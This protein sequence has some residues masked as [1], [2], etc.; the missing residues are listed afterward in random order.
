MRTFLRFGVLA[1]AGMIMAVPATS[2]G[3]QKWIDAN[4]QVH[5][6]DAPPP[7]A[8]TQAVRVD[9]PPPTRNPQPV[10]IPPPPAGAPAQY[11][12]VEAERRARLAE[13]EKRNQQ[14]LAAQAAV[15]A[16]TQ[17]LNDHALIA[18][19]RKARNSYCN[20]GVNVIRQKE[21]ERAMSQAADQQTAAMAQGR[22][23]PPGQRITPVTPC[24]WPQT[25]STEKGKR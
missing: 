3:V 2:A 15:Q 7:G 5:Y 4:G 19:C 12:S 9:A 24:Q 17:A 8:N 14:G 16:R 22:V 1:V 25:C 21:Y 13:A 20:E 18:N 11:G 23:I 10:Y 6:G